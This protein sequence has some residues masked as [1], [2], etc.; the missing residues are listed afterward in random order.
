MKI[1]T[2]CREAHSV[3]INS[4]DVGYSV[5]GAANVLHREKHATLIQL[6]IVLN[7][8]CYFIPLTHILLCFLCDS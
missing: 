3:L 2:R 8:N 4:T 7:K 5:A 6:I 1:N